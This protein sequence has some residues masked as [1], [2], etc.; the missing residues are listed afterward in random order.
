[1]SEQR[2]LIGAGY[3]ARPGDGRAEFFRNLW[4]PNLYAHAKP[5]KV[6]VI[7]D[8]GSKFPDGCQHPFLGIP[9]DGDLGYCGQLLSGE[10]NNQFPTGPSVLM[11][12]A[13]LAYI[14]ELDFVYFEQDAL[15]FGDCVGKMYEQIGDGG[16]IFGARSAQMPCSNTVFLIRHWFIPEFVAKYAASP[17]EDCEQ[18]LCEWKFAQFRLDDP[19]KWK[20]YSFGVDRDHHD[21]WMDERPVYAQKLSQDEL[22]KLK[23]K[24]MI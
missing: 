16:I 22:A 23:E 3:H 19:A 2:Y 21:G 15:W 13:L 4:L 24:G 7:A 20:T 18:H 11:A 17:K 10:K 14:D 5:Q 1:M 6:V 9:L 12:L 8:S